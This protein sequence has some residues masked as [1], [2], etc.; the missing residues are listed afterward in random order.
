MA[1]VKGKVVDSRISEMPLARRL[2]P[3]DELAIVQR[4]PG[5]KKETRRVHLRDLKEFLR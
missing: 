5:G 3:G 2:E 4:G 1:T